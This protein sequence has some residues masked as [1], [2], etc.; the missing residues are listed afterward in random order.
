MDPIS[1]AVG[2]GVKYLPELVSYLF[3]DNAG[4]VAKDVGGIIKNVTGATTLDGAEAALSAN[5]A[6]IAELRKQ[7]L[8]IKDREKERRHVERLAEM[9]SAGELA[10]QHFQD[11][12]SARATFGQNQDVIKLAKWLLASFAIVSLACIGGCFA[13]LGG[14]IKVDPGNVGLIAAVFGF[15]GTIFGAI[16]G[17]AMVVVSFFFGSSQVADA[18]SNAMTNAVTNFGTALTVKRSP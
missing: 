18:H 7:A 6:L 10:V 1:I 16:A 12:S 14:V 8:E 13:V 4:E 5:P 17:A 9:K 3:G 15:L 11:T 2:L